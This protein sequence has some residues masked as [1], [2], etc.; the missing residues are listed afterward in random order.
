MN[1]AG[2]IVT[3]HV[4]TFG[5]PRD[6]ARSLARDRER[7]AQVPGLRFGRLVFVGSR[8]TEAMSAGWVDPRRQMA[9]CVWDDEAALERF[10][11]G[12]PIARAWREQTEQ[13]CEVRARPFRAHGTYRGL[14]PLAGLAPE[15]APAGPVALL[16]FANIPVRGL[17]YFYRGIRRSTHVLLGSAGLIAAVAGP[18]RFGRGGMTF[19]I[20]RSLPDALGFSYR[21]D[22]HRGIVRS[23][24]EDRRLIDSMFLRVR[25]Y[26]AE[27]DWFPW[28]RFAS[29]F[30]ELTRAMPGAP[31]PARPAASPSAPASRSPTA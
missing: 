18:E 24:R 14:E 20:W 1:G 15:N 17:V 21:R 26:A 5:S 30:E 4:F 22:P 9:M 28:S 3:A 2:P 16:T 23:V 11:A 6:A 29:G 12:S 31:A 19:T 13:H 10:R 27:G 8:R 7:L 25:P